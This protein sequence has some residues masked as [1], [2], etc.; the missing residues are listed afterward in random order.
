MHQKPPI[1][2]Y[3]PS[4]LK[5]MRVYYLK[6]SFFTDLGVCND[7]RHKICWV[8]RR[9]GKIGPSDTETPNTHILCMY[10]HMIEVF[11]PCGSWFDGFR[12]YSRY[13]KVTTTLKIVINHMFM[14]KNIKN[15]KKPPYFHASTTARKYKIGNND[16]TTILGSVNVKNMTPTTICSSNPTENVLGGA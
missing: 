7:P 5:L 14:M 4:G 2:H 16:S 1:F 10:H 9:M 11:G 12:W 3:F 15:N 6:N 13:G 8:R